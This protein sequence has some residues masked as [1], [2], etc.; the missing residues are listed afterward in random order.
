MLFLHICYVFSLFI[1]GNSIQIPYIDNAILQS[2][3]NS[4]DVFL[5]NKTCD[6]CLCIS[7][8]SY[9]ILNCLPNNTC[10]LFSIFPLTYQI[11]IIPGARLYFPQR[12]FPNISQCCMPD[13]NYL[14]NRL[15][16]ASQTTVSIPNPRE[17]VI[18]NH[19]YLATV[20]MKSNHLDRFY[21]TNLTRISQT[22][23]Q[24]SS[25]RTIAY[26][27][28]AFFVA[29]NN[30]SMTI[31]DSENL[32]TLND[33]ILTSIDGPRGIMFLNNG[34]TMV[35]SSINNNYLVFFNRSTVVPIKYIFTFY[36]L[37]NCSGPHGLW[38]VNDSFFYA[39]SYK[40]NSIY[41]YSSFNS[42]WQEKYVFK[43]PSMNNN[44]TG[45]THLTID[46]CQRFWISLETDTT[47]IYDQQGNLLGNLTIANSKIFDIKLIDNY[48]MYI[49]DTLN[50]RTIRFD[51]NIQC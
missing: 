38:R 49:S 36:Q 37:I 46:E 7:F 42:I 14:L 21:P 30:N 33:V 45:T 5:S 3:S 19:G 50:N 9:S 34:Q 16:M 27:N 8:L 51:P 17:I 31:V 32:T 23:I 18:D 4:N 2:R 22:I 43:V 26:N 6:Q 35:I 24:I 25:A 48:I 28:G 13:I 1:L 10:Q 15:K 47:L 11:K 41:S 40:D 29:S 20:E 12:L 39:T 44:N